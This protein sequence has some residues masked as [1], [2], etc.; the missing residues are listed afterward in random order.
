MI[1]MIAKRVKVNIKDK[2]R[3]SKHHTTRFDPCLRDL[4][5]AL[6]EIDDVREKKMIWLLWFVYFEK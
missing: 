5:Q 3:Y 1:P 6:L 2:T 4:H